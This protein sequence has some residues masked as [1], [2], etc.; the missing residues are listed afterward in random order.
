MV[1]SPGV[2]RWS[3]D[4][5]NGHGKSTACR[6]RHPVYLSLGKLSLER[7]AVYHS[8]FEAMYPD[9]HFETASANG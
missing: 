1:G 2:Y 5:A 9:T 4:R 6:T 3:S 7:G 8:L